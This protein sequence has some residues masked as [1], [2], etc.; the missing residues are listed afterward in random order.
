MIQLIG[1]GGAGKTTTGAALAERLGARFVDLDAEFTSRHGSISAYLDEKGYAAYANA[2]VGIFGDLGGGPGRPDIVALSSGFMTYADDVHPVYPAW[3]QQVA[4]SPS[5][6]VLLP[7]LQFEACV[8]EIVRR[9]R[10]RPFSRSKAREE[11]VV[12]ARLPIYL[13][14][15]GRKVATLRPIE[16]VVDE[17]IS[18]LVSGGLWPA[19]D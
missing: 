16:T 15:P 1:P 19:P 13:A 10:D 11:Q 17:L 5:T 9:Q 2:N 8:K 7:S 3:R 4:S 14:M 12:R 18:A 6:F